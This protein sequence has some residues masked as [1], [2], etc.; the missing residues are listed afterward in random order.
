[1]EFFFLK[2]ING[3]VRLSPWDFQGP[4]EVRVFGGILERIFF[5]SVETRM[6]KD[7]TQSEVFFPKVSN[8]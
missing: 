4:T 6:P 8:Y 1:M 5:L 3:H 7:I 2:R